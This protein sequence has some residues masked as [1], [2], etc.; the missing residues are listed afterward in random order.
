MASGADDGALAVS[1]HDHQG[2]IVIIVVTCIVWTVLVMCIRLFSRFHFNG[3]FS[4]DD[5]LVVLGTA[6]QPCFQLSVNTN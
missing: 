1:P 5:A 6:G 4:W 2:I 3:V